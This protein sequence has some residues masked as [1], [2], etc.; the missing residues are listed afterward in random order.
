MEN[1]VE[2]VIQL[3]AN[4]SYYIEQ[5]YVNMEKNGEVCLDFAYKHN[6]IEISVYVLPNGSEVLPTD[7]EDIEQ[8]KT[9]DYS[10]RVWNYAYREVL[11][12]PTADELVSAIAR[13]I[14]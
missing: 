5:E 7:L 8:L 14:I 1:T 6:E 11:E 3:M 12:K 9:T 13:C 10:F 4:R 2:A